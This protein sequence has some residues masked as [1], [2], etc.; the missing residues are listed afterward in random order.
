M[1][2]LTSLQRLRVLAGITFIQLVRMKVFLFLLFFIVLFLAANTLHFNEIL[3]PE[4]LG[5]QQLTLMKESTMG[6]LRLFCLIFGVTATALLLPRD[7]EDRILYTLLCRP[8]PRWEYLTGKLLG[9]MAVLVAV[10]GCMDLIFSGVLEWRTAQ[11]V[12]EQTAA[13]QASNV[14]AETIK[15]ITGR[16]QAQGLTWSLQSGILLLLMESLVL[17]AATLFLSIIST[18]TIFSIVVGFSIYMIGLFQQDVASLWF[19]GSGAG[20]SRWGEIGQFLLSVI[21]PNFRIYALMDSAI[22]G[23]NIALSLIGEIALVSLS[24]VVMYLTAATWIFRKKEF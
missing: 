19:G 6:I 11:L 12:A 15:I 2:I 3:G 16:I 4:T 20:T 13:L 21:F 10:V 9:V 24:Y 5:E 14:D 18:S 1:V 23:K 17:C 7:A 8:L 22:A